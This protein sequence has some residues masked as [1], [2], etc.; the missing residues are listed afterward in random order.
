MNW[1]G[2]YPPMVTYKYVLEGE[3]NVEEEKQECS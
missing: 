1:P 3:E 2:S